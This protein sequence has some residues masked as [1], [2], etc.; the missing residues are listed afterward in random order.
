MLADGVGQF[1][2]TLVLAA[3]GLVLFALHQIRPEMFSG[4][5]SADDIFP[6]FIG[7][8]LPIGLRGLVVAALY[9]SVM[10]SL[11]SGINSI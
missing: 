6:H 9:A 8:I 7:T 11:D 1:L 10:S 5:N 3:T 2:V 4:V